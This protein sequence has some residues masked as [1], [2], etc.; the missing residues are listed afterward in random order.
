[1]SPGSSGRPRRLYGNGQL[2]VTQYDLD[3]LTLAELP[4][5]V[6]ASIR[7]AP[8][9]STPTPTSVIAALRERVPEGER[10]ASMSSWVMH[11]VMDILR[12]TTARSPTSGP[13]ACSGGRC[14]KWAGGWSRKAA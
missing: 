6:L 3:G 4:G 11:A 7:D 9:P 13:S 8:S 2:I 5:V 14:S 1:M 10:R 12:T